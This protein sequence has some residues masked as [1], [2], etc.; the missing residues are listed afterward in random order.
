MHD[1][2]RVSPSELHATA[3]RLRGHRSE[4]AGTTHAAGALARS[5]GH[6]WAGAAEGRFQALYAQWDRASRDMLDALDGIADLLDHGGHL[7]HGT[8]S[9]IATGLR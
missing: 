3:G 6:H 8:D 2:F 7:Y 4:L 1:G 9:E 5:S